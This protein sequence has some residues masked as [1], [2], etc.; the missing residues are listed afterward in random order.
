MLS[1]WAEEGLK[2]RVD[3][4]LGSIGLG[5]I[6]QGLQSLSCKGAINC[7]HYQLRLD[8][9]CCGEREMD[10]E[11]VVFLFKITRKAGLRPSA[12]DSG[13][14][15]WGI[16]FASPNPNSPTSPALTHKNRQQF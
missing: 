5:G 13:H 11:W 2:G 6:I 10:R 1:C 9:D 4:T 16:C 14:L 8:S 15:G 12:A 7:C 3:G